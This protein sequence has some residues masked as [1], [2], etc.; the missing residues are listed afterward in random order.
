MFEA[1]KVYRRLRVTIIQ[2]TKFNLFQ[3]NPKYKK[4]KAACLCFSESLQVAESHDD[5]ALV[6]TVPNDI[7]KHKKCQKH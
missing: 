1:E 5:L 7:A 4:I 3:K 6:T 2:E